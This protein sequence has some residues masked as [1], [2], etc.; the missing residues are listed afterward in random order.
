MPPIRKK[1]DKFDDLDE[2]FKSEIASMATGDINARIA[3]W[4]KLV[5]ATT[6]TMKADQDLEQRKEAVKIAAEPYRQDIK[7]ARLRIAFAARVLQD[8]GVD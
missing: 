5:E 3:E 4:A 1:K 8:R 6:E 7:G 2:G